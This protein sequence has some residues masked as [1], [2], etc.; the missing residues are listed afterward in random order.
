MK[1]NEVQKKL[2]RFCDGESASQEANNISQ[3]LAGC[4]PCR[5]THQQ[6]QML[7]SLLAAQEHDYPSYLHHKIMHQVQNQPLPKPVG[8][9]WKLI[10]VAAGLAFSIYIGT[11]LG[12]KAM[13]MSVVKTEINAL[14]FGQTTLLAE[15]YSGV[16]HE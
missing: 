16:S 7:N 10:P 5:N 2:T 9:R 12:T 15:E 1:C 13:P 6:M 4:S 14:N 11:F 8:L 3:H